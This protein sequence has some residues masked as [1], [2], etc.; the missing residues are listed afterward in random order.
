VIDQQHILAVFTESRPG[1]ED[2]FNRWYDEVHVGDLLVVPGIES[3]QRFHI[4]ATEPPQSP[5]HRWLGIYE[6]SRNPNEV[7]EALR[8]T[9]EQ[10]TM[11]PAYDSDRTVRFYYTAISNRRT[12]D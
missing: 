5:S 12:A 8:A 10:R 1:R 6:L 3:V 2:E 11:S 9:R 4:S 7:M